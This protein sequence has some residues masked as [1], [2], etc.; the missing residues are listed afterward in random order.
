[1]LP[2]TLSSQINA[3]QKLLI[4]GIYVTISCFLCIVADQATLLRKV[5]HNPS[6]NQH[7]LNLASSKIN[8]VKKSNIPIGLTLEEAGVDNM[9]QLKVYHSTS[10]MCY[11]KPTNFTIP[12]F[13]LKQPQG[14]LIPGGGC[15]L[16][17]KARNI[18]SW[19]Q[20]ENEDVKVVF[21]YD[22][23]ADDPVHD[24][25]SDKLMGNKEPAEVPLCLLSVTRDAAIAL[26][27]RRKVDEVVSDERISVVWPA[28]NFLQLPS[29]T[30]F[31]GVIYELMACVLITLLSFTI[32]AG[33][34]FWRWGD[35]FMVEISI[36]GIMISYLEGEDDHID[37]NVLLSEEQVLDLP[38]IKFG[39]T[40]DEECPPDEA[41]VQN[42]CN[43]TMCSVCIDDF[44]EGEMLRVLPCG[45]T[46]HT[47]CIL[48]W[49]TTRAPNCPLCKDCI[50]ESKKGN[51]KRC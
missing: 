3:R 31:Q 39:A 48:P 36:E 26:R 24:M 46:Y 51:K 47:D 16:E 21:I 5:F 4:F 27:K 1:M 32:T 23:F 50:S 38:Q 6:E 10:L 2:R 11:R 18:V 44:E 45:H 9:D 28:D 41:L 40:N 14:I 19:Y 49:L 25:D 8:Y 15:S 29:K 7:G 13:G 35:S 30:K 12:N 37:T 42:L 33:I 20:E 22:Y 43:S 17:E 34:L